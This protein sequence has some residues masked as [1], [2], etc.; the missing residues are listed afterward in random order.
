MGTFWC[1]KFIA[2]N[3]RCGTI[4]LKI[5]FGNCWKVKVVKIEKVP[6]GIS[7][8]DLPIEIRSRQ[9]TNALYL[10]MPFSAVEKY[11]EYICFLF[12]LYFFFCIFFVFL[13]PY[14]HSNETI[15]NYIYVPKRNLIKKSNVVINSAL[16]H[17]CSEKL[18][19]FRKVKN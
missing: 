16:M 4:C 13:G 8:S 2:N 17:I 5:Y 15:Y 6:P 1:I 19:I 12:S 14:D 3:D 10:E 18:V 11:K 9:Q 7:I